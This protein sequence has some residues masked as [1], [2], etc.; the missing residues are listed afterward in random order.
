MDGTKKPMFNNIARMDMYYWLFFR[1]AEKIGSYRMEKLVTRMYG[2]YD[3]RK[4]LRTNNL[5][6]DL[7]I[8]TFGLQGKASRR[9]SCC[10][11]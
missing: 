3:V 1:P 9:T 6:F 5:P 10:K 7:L 11:K 8:F 2:T 4:G